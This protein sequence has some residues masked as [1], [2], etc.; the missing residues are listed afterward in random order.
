MSLSFV[1]SNPVNYAANATAILIGDYTPADDN[2]YFLTRSTSATTLYVYRLDS[3][4]NEVL[5]KTITLA[6]G[7]E[8]TEIKLRSYRATHRFRVANTDG[9]P[10]TIYVEA[11]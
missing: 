6:A 1:G 8:E 4:S 9:V 10:G 5:R 11:P 7:D 2:L 3:L